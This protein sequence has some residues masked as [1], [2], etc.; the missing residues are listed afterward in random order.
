MY[1]CLLIQASD[2]LAID[3]LKFLGTSLDDHSIRL[4]CDILNICGDRLSRK[5]NDK[6]MVLIFFRMLQY[7]FLKKADNEVN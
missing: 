5:Q 7:I 2:I 3:L 4:T 6:D 1:V